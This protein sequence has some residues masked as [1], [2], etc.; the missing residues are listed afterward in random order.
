VKLGIVES[1]MTFSACAISEK[2]FR[3]CFP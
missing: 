3:F 2:V 1:A